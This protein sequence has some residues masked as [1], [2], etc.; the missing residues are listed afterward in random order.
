MRLIVS[1][2]RA[3]NWSIISVLSLTFP[4]CFLLVLGSGFYPLIALLFAIAQM[5]LSGITQGAWNWGLSVVVLWIT[6]QAAFY[7]WLIFVVSRALTKI[8]LMAHD[9]RKRKLAKVACIAAPFIS[10]FFPIWGSSG[11]VDYSE[12]GTMLNMLRGL[13][14]AL[15]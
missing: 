12:S 4:C 14:R 3:L 5:V 8:I 10:W 7:G 1:S 13:V 9:E 11:F 6:S 2:A 15:F